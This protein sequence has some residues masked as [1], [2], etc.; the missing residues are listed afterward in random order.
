MQPGNGSV[1]AVNG[2]SA[3][4][5]GADVGL[6]VGGMLAAGGCMSGRVGVGTTIAGPAPGVDV[7]SASESK[8]TAN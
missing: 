6:T 3:L 7:A 8:V 4:A 2:T 5:K 1:R